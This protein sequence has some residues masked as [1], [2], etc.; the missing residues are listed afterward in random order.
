MRLTAVMIGLALALAV[1]GC[2]RQCFLTQ[3][4]YEHYHDLGLPPNLPTDVKAGVVPAGMALPVPATVRSP[5]RPVYP[6]SLAEALALALEH[7]TPGSPQLNGTT[8]D[9][10]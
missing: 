10:L 7:G 9:I 1:A 2:Q 4:D 6:L 3:C 8:T 5:E